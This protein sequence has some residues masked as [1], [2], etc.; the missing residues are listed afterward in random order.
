[1]IESCEKIR[2]TNLDNTSIAESALRRL[3]IPYRRACLKEG[4]MYFCSLPSE[5]T[6]DIFM[7][8]DGSMKLWRFVGSAPVS[9]AGMRCEYRRPDHPDTAIG[10]EVTD[11]GDLC[12]YAK[13][14]VDTGNPLRER[15]IFRMIAGY[16]KMIT[17]G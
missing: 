11:E 15:R 13:Q 7:G 14:I 1:M 12:L 2:M 8:S 5:L 3:D 6:F 16:S 9:E 4:I 17:T 10:F